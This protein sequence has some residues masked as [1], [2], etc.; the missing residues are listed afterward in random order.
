M[1]GYIVLAKSHVGLLAL[2]PLLGINEEGVHYSLVCNKLNPMW[3]HS[4][5]PPARNQWGGPLYSLVCNKLNPMNQW[6]GLLVN[7]MWGPRP[8][9]RNQ[10]GR[11]LYSLVCNKLNPMWGHS[12]R[13]PARNQWVEPLYSLVCNTE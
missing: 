13:P 12:P 11:P 7:P 3:G 10:W 4:P 8:P 2:A 5:R 1:R 9:A 6:V